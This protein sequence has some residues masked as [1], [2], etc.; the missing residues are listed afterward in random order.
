M[1]KSGLAS[2]ENSQPLQRANYAKIK[3]CLFFVESKKS[4]I[5]SGKIYEDKAERLTAKSFD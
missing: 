2:F 4:R 5:L 1:K 3:K